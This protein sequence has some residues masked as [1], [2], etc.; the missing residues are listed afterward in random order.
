[1]AGR[2]FTILMT[3]STA[4]PVKKFASTFVLCTIFSGLPYMVLRV[5]IKEKAERT[6]TSA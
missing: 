6:R 3:T 1:M 5:G 4:V 2:S